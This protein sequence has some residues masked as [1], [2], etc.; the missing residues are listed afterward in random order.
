MRK[1]ND[2]HDE[3]IKKEFD[4][5]NIIKVQNINSPDNNSKEVNDL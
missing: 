5:D 1:I 4:K 3:Q 2:K